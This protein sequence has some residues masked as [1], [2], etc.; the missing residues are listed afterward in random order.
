LTPVETGPHGCT[1]VQVDAEG[2]V[3]LRPIVAEAVR[4]CR[5]RIEVHSGTRRQEL[6]SAMTSRVNHLR[7]EASRPLL[8]AWTLDGSGR[9]DSIFADEQERHK[10]LL[11]LRDEFG[12]GDPPVW[13]T[14]VE[15]EPPDELPRQ[16]CEEDSI[17]GDY[18]R[19]VERYESEP[20]APLG[21]ERYLEPGHEFLTHDPASRA[22]SEGVSFPTAGQPPRELVRAL[23][24]G[25][26]QV[27]RE[28]LRA[29][30]VLGADL[31][32]GDEAPGR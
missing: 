8:A 11:W 1:L 25:S 14:E 16:W 2:V 24:V 19:V 15:I 12:G 27:R 17:L 30:A 10:M 32:R 5:E 31:L 26:R 18:L 13:S 7:S 28:L 20:E 22:R 6:R 4:W 3:G 29:A 21:L 9:F 23:E